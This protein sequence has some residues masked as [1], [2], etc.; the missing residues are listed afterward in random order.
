MPEPLLPVVRAKAR[1]TSVILEHP[2]VI[3]GAAIDRVTM[4]LVDVLVRDSAGNTTR[5][6]GASMLSVPW[7]WPSSLSFEARDRRM[8]E[9]VETSARLVVGSD[10]ADPFAAWE[11]L[12]RRAA[13][14]P[15]A[16]GIPQVALLLCIAAADSSLHD[17]GAAAQGLSALDFASRQSP[18]LGSIADAE[19]FAA[20]HHRTRVP[21]QRVVGLSDGIGD[22]D[23]L[24]RDIQEHGIRHL[25]IKLAGEAESD[26]AR[27]TAIHDRFGSL[28]LTFALDA[29]EGY[30]RP[31]EFHLLLDTLRSREELWRSIR[32]VEQPAPRTVHDIRPWHPDRIPADLLPP[33]VLD[34]G[35]VDVDQ[36]RGAGERGWSGVAIKASK[37]QSFAILSFLHARAAGLFTVLQDLTTVDLALEHSAGLAAALPFTYRAFECNSLQY[38]PGANDR[39]RRRRPDMLRLQDG[40]VAVGPTPLRGLY[41]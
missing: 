19:A 6:R 17:G 11:T 5:G 20:K 13:V 28:G 31:E 14:L 37:G 12:R 33:L 3:A 10:A 41:V 30:R 23:A 29:N 21:V 18:L 2:L 1:F 8:R 36:L 35:H 38:A 9:L 16:E 26:A 22:E 32:Y 15:E 7:A 4:A 39:L 27:V 25:K 40:S 34:E 24:C